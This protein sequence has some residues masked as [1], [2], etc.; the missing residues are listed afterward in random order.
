MLAG[1]PSPVR[2]HP[3]LIEVEHNEAAAPHVPQSLGL[4]R[5][6]ICGSWLRRNGER[7]DP[8][9]VWSVAAPA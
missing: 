1:A 7:D 3:D 8:P 4:Y 6:S 2:P 5:C 9:G